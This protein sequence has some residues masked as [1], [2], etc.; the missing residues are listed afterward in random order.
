MT[1]RSAAPPGHSSTAPKL[2]I[3]IRCRN[4]GRAL[5]RVF[6]A[7]SQ[8]RCTFRW[9]V[10][11]VDN[12]SEDDT[13]AICQQFGAKR[14]LIA[15][16]EFSYGRATNMGVERARGDLV[17][18]LS[19]HALP[20]GSHFLSGAVEP[21]EDDQLAAARCLFVGNSKQIATWDQPRD[22]HYGSRDEQRK[23]E[24]GVAWLSEYPTGGCCVIRRSVWRQIK[25]DET[26]ESNE[27]KLWA[28]H[29][30]AS[31]YRV[32]VCAEAFWMYTRVYERRDRWRRQNR[33][34]LALY[35]I[36]GRPPL[37]WRRYLLLAVRAFCV[38]PVVAIQHITH[39]IGWNTHLVTIPWQARMHPRS[40]SYSE[41]DIKR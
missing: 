28:S 27:D 38:A 34:Q 37:S 24:S 19:A 33:Q 17:M 16:R 7:L 15:R 35:R 4:E 1:L 6:E 9:E 36:T 12:E 21:F 29:V 22:I 20:L 3:V 5:T 32:R 11:V 18:L 40:G 25:Y 30:L 8:Q 23:A 26:L 10:V 31:G 39:E 13:A 41:F 2:S 14:I